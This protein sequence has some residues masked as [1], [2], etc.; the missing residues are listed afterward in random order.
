MT[1]QT[2]PEA[3]PQE[4]KAAINPTLVKIGAIGIALGIGLLKFGFPLV[5]VASHNVLSVLWHWVFG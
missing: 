4:A 5:Y 2:R 3:Q 1:S